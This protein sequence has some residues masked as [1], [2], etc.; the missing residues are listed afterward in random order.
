MT[1][2]DATLLFVAG[3][4]SGAVNAVAG[5]GTVVPFGAMTLVGVPPI[6][7][8]ATSSVTQFPGY[9]TST[10]AYL[11]DIRHFWREALLL[12]VI[13]A[14]GALAGSLILLALDNPSFR[15]LVP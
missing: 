2:F 8:S 10:L 14:V 1:F 4:I 11:A 6:V 5:A 9:I 12:C 3:F 13:S 7:A 15:T